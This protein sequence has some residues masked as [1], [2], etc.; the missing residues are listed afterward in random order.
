MQFTC[1]YREMI[2]DTKYDHENTLFTRKRPLHH[3]KGRSCFGYIA[4]KEFLF[5]SIQQCEIQN[6]FFQKTHI[7]FSYTFFLDYQVIK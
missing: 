2:T 5:Y 4:L 1:I 3:P 7:K 6:Y